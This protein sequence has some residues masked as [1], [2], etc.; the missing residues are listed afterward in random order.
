MKGEIDISD[1]EGRG[2]WAARIAAAWRAAASAALFDFAS[3][4][5]ASKAAA[6]Q[7]MENA[8]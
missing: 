2:V 7:L 1:D 3:S 6:F 8:R 5:F 4:H